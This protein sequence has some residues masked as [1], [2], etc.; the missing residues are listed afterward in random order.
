MFKRSLDLGT[1]FGIRVQLHWSLAII[2]GM[3]L[4][5]LGAGVFPA[6]HPQWSPAVVWATALAAALIFFGS[7]L[8]HELSHSLT[9]RLFGVPVR[10]ITLFL[11]GGVA[12]IEE[13]PSKP[14]HEGI[15]AAAGP[16]MSLAIG[17]GAFVLFA[18]LNPQAAG[19][20]EV[21]P[22]AMVEALGPLETILLWVGP[23]NVLLAVFNMVPAF[24]LDGGRVLRA[25]LWGATDDVVKATRWAAATTQVVSWAMVAAGIAMALGFYVPLLGTGLVGGMWL[26]IIGWFIGRAAQ[27]SYEQL[28]VQQT[29][30]QVPLDRVMRQPTAAVPARADLQTFA[31][32]YVWAS[33]Q[34]AFAVCIGDTFVGVVRAEVLDRIPRERWRDT[35]V[36]E[37]MTAA[38]DFPTIDSAADAQQ[39]FKRMTQ[40][41]VT[42]LP[43]IDAHGFRGLVRYADLMKWLRL[44]GPRDKRAA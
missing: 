1:L 26:A 29:L 41:Q 23:I 16:V 43:V 37:V 15:I 27:A 33:D 38:E 32:D 24:P 42:E 14:S 19:A 4:L 40:R 39:A 28:V 35:A 9:A 44:H 3:I 13:D 21:A 8:A 18:L 11:F 22:M 34:D 36:A 17:F 20:A 12:N 30:D 10:S 5:H 2:F 31:D 7:V 6:W 25:I